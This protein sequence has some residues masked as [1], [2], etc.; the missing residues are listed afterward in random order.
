MAYT[1]DN[2]A[3]TTCPSATIVLKDITNSITY[4]LPD[5]S[6]SWV[7]GLGND[8]VKLLNGDAAASNI[9]AGVAVGR[10]QL[11]L[12]MV[13]GVTTAAWFNNAFTLNQE[14]NTANYYTLTI[15]RNPSD[16]SPLNFQSCKFDSFNLSCRFGQ[17]GAEQMVMMTVTLWS[18]DPLDG[19]AL[20]LPSAGP[21][22]ALMGFAQ[23]VFTG[24][25]QVS[26]INIGVTRND[27]M[28]PQV[29][30]AG[31]NADL[32][33]QSGGVIQGVLMGGVTLQQ[34]A[35]AATIPGLNDAEATLTAAFG[36]TGDGESI[37]MNMEIIS[38]TGNIDQ[39]IA[40][41]NTSYKLVAYGSPPTNASMIQ[42]TDL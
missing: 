21:T 16:A 4:T 22:G 24:A 3:W 11:A 6:A 26:A 12:G 41:V 25:S 40:Y 31:G 13:P 5:V 18:A 8:V 7:V 9:V 17:T 23:S 1:A 38:Q 27:V 10:I 20:S 28:I 15:Y 30:S 39:G 33:Y 37:A 19:T 34:S 42:W 36:S 35:L 32:P 2:A 29:S 14:A